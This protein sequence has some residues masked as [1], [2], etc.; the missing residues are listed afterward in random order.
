MPSSRCR[1]VDSAEW[2][3][4]V[5]D[6]LVLALFRGTH[7]IPTPSP[8]H[9]IGVEFHFQIAPT[10]DAPR[11]LTTPWTEGLS[12][13]TAAW[14]TSH[15]ALAFLHLANLGYAPLYREDNMWEDAGCCSEFSF[16]K[17]EQAVG[18]VPHCAS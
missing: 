12:F 8:L 2:D 5:P 10:W 15:M 16:L 14:T 9:Q 6:A 1:W 3:A 4:P 18:P 13:P 17:V 7:P 11:N